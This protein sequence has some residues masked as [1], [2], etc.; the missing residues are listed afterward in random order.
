M[1]RARLAGGT[2]AAISMRAIKAS[3][4]SLISVE[5]PRRRSIT[6][7][8]KRPRRIMNLIL[9]ILGVLVLFTLYLRWNE[10]RMLYFPTKTLELSPADLGWKFEEVS[11]TT[12][13][14]VRVHGWYFPSSESDATRTILFLHGNAG[15]ISHRFEK[16][17]ILRKLDAHILAID[18]R[19]YGKSEG[20]P[21]EAGTY[22]DA[23]AAYDYLLAKGI[24]PRAIILYGESLG[25]AV[26]VELASKE[27]VG[28]MI[29]E[30]PFTSVAA[31]G[32]K[33]FP[34]I[35]VRLLVQ[36]KYDTLSK[37]GQ[38]KTPLLILHSPTDEIIPF[39]HARAVHDAANPPKKLVELKGTHNEGFL[40]TGESYYAAME[41]FLKR[42][43]SL[44]QDR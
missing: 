5:F 41:D 43:K 28:A 4:Y 13:D 29:L 17:D 31:I 35:P 1:S 16:F 42:L 10:P 20:T 7:R 18:Y 14:G 23:K 3:F 11:L 15:N 34:F 21:N 30:S 22:A 24:S 39:A 19:G 6:E 33:M 37:I 38:I 25:C 27:V 9:V 36:N 2:V 26:A 44:D 40:T 8:M 12:A 32:Q